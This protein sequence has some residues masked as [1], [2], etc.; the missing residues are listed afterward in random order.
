[1]KLP[2]SAS[3][4]LW[5]KDAIIY[6]LPVK[7]FYDGNG[8]GIGD[9]RGLHREARLPAGPR[10]DLPLAAAVLSVAA[11]QTTA[12]TSS[13]YRS[14]HPS[15][16]TLDDFKRFL[17]A[18]HARRMQVIIELVL[19]HTSDQHPWFQRARRAAPG[20]PERDYYV[21]SDTR[22][23]LSPMRASSSSIPSVELDV[24]SGGAGVLLAPVLSSPAGSQL[25]Q[26]RRCCSEM[27]EVIDFW[28]DLGVD[29]FRLDAVPYLVEREG[30]T[31][32]NLPETHAIIK[33][34]RRHIDE[35]LPAPDAAG[36][37][38]SRA[39]PTCGPTSATATNA[40]WP[41]TSR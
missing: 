15:Y 32:E 33:A 1:M 24:G 14:I 37:G 25:R 16:G 22:S 26:S 4:P 9:F 12:T 41:I 27:L 28:L 40:T 39:R 8:D 20:T 11:P 21:W 31:C 29:G 38:Q 7:S 6:E 35:R 5:Y 19:N 34:I 10:R 2:G 18:A 17:Q 23:A 30:T 36:R 13:D 3:D